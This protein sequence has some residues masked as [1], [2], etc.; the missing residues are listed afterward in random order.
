MRR[1]IYIEALLDDFHTFVRAIT[2][3]VLFDDL[4]EIANICNVN[5]SRQQIFA[6][7]SKSRSVF[8]EFY[9]ERQRRGLYRVVGSV[10][11]TPLV[12][13]RLAFVY[14]LINFHQPFPVFSFLVSF[15]AAATLRR[16]T[17]RPPLS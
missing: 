10:V 14:N 4:Q 5:K 9:A 13:L 17:N 1:V 8:L 15:I 3:I 7:E 16:K 12:Q 2:R 6:D 11:Q